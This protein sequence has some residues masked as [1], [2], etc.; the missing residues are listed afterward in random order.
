MFLR[1]EGGSSLLLGPVWVL[2]EETERGEDIRL[3]SVFGCQGFSLGISFPPISLDFL[4][5][6][7][8]DPIVVDEEGGERTKKTTF[9]LT[10]PNF[11]LLSSSHCRHGGTL[12]EL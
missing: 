2:V 4:N 7:E 8:R 9:G 3:I 1:L 10:I 5:G 6:W 11:S 12:N